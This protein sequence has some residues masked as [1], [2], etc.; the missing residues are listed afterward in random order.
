MA[1]NYEVVARLIAQSI[2]LQTQVKLASLG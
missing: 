2:Q 1:T